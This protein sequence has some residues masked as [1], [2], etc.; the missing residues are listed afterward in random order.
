[1]KKKYK[2][3]HLPSNTGGNPN[4]LSHAL[5]SLGVDS[6]TMTLKQGCVEY[7]IDIILWGKNDSIVARLLKQFLA[8]KDAL[9]YYDIIHFNF[10]T[11]LFSPICHYSPKNTPFIKK[12]LRILYSLYSQCM[13][14]IELKAFHILGKKMFIHYQ[15]DD[16]RQGDFS[17]AHFQYS[18][19]SQVGEEYYNRHSDRFKR[20]SI[21]KMVKYCSQI[22]AVNPDLLHVLPKGSRFIPYCHIILEEWQPIYTQNQADKPL[23]IGHA[24]SHRKAKGTDLILRALA[25]LKTEGYCY[26][27]ILVEG[28]TYAEA[29]KKYETMDVFVDQLFAGWYGGVAVEVMAL[30]KPVLV[31]IREEDLKFIPEEMKNDLPFINVNPDTIKDGLRNVLEMPRSELLYL[32]KKCRNYVERW[33]NMFKIAEEIKKDYEISFEISNL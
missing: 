20:K 25:E 3:L 24:P 16:A 10:G 6:T 13:Q 23:K 27:L 2:V 12:I 11:T 18:I 28:L 8:L 15:G 9:L 4:G 32:A 22:Y 33:H 17:L 21:Q 26:E 31:Y 7:P 29:R 14:S 19:A 30:G 5:N 1:M